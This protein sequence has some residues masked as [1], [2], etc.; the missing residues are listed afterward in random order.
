MSLPFWN[1]GTDTTRTIKFKEQHMANSNETEWTPY[2]NSFPEFKEAQKEGKLKE[3]KASQLCDL[4]AKL[5]RLD[6]KFRGTL[7][8]VNDELE[9]V[10]SKVAANNH[11]LE[12]LRKETQ[13]LTNEIV[14]LR[15]ALRNNS[16][17]TSKYSKLCYIELLKLQGATFAPTS[18]NN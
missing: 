6:S 3:Y 18:K 1:R 8:G 5:D 15:E 7:Q 10:D 2:K 12:L 17:E 4:H 16:S 11:L 14:S 9:R 13:Q